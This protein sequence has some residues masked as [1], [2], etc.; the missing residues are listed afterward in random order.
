MKFNFITLFENLIK[1][2][3]DDSILKRALD[4]NLFEVDFINPR[5]LVKTS[6]KK[7]MII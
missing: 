4:K 7:L 2:Y 1:P 6:I 3:F 5:D